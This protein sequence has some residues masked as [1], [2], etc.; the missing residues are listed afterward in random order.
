MKYNTSRTNRPYLFI[1]LKKGTLAR[2][3]PPT[4]RRCAP[5][6]SLYLI[7]LNLISRKLR[8]NSRFLR[9]GFDGGR[10]V[11]KRFFN[12]NLIVGSLLL[13]RRGLYINI[14]ITS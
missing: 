9:A 6:H 13:Y 10:R 5:K 2:E 4:K 8:E 14:S 11:E 12:D 1:F 7:N 3:G